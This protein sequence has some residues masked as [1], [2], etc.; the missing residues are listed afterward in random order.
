MLNLSMKS[1][2]TL[3]VFTQPSSTEQAT[4]SVKAVKYVCMNIDRIPNGANL[5][6]GAFEKIAFFVF[7]HSAPPIPFA[8]FQ[9][10]PHI[11]CCS[12]NQLHLVEEGGLNELRTKSALSI[13]KNRSSLICRSFLFITGKL[14]FLAK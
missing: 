9:V 6:L 13:C 10:L 5:P 12:T 4:R 14:G 1:N 7:F 3:Q 2:T 11:V 8:T